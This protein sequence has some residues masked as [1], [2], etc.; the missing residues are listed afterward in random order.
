ML[1]QLY[2]CRKDEEGRWAGQL[3]RCAAN[4]GALA[5][6]RGADGGRGASSP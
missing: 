1:G 3:S 4:G 2:T 5:E 6:P